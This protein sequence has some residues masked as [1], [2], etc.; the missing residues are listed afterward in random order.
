MN[1]SWWQSVMS[2]F[3]GRTMALLAFQSFIV[4][5][6]W[7]D[8]IW[9]VNNPQ[10]ITEA[11]IYPYP[12]T[13]LYNI[14]TLAFTC[15]KTA[16]TVGLETKPTPRLE[17]KPTPR[18]ETKPTPRLETKPVATRGNNYQTLPIVYSHRAS[19]DIRATEL[20]LNTIINLPHIVYK[21]YVP[22]LF[23]YTKKTLTTR[24]TGADCPDEREILWPQELNSQSAQ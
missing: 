15:H 13:G 3:F 18:L 14:G 22:V 16:P 5:I 21:L 4:C 24:T 19:N 1:D 6:A 17:T 11:F 7:N 2:G 8:S 10:V 23:I 20:L 12:I 9:A